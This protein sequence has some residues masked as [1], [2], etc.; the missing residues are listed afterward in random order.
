MSPMPRSDTSEARAQTGNARRPGSTAATTP[1]R[2][3][4][5]RGLG[6]RVLVL[7]LIAAGQE[8]AVRALFPL[9]EVEGFNRV[10]YQLMAGTHPR[11]RATLRRGLVYDQVV[12]ES[13]PDG[14]RETHRLNIYGFRSNDFAIDPPR[15]RGRILVIGDSVAEGQGA[16]ESATI[17]AELSRRTRNE[18]NPPEILNLGVIAANLPRLTLLTRDAVSLLRPTDVIL[19][20]YANDLP[21]PP[22][23]PSLDGPAAPVRRLQVEPWLPRLVVLTGQALADEPIH[24]RWPRRSIRFFPAVPDPANPWT[25]AEKPPPNVQPRLFQEMRAGTL[26]PWLAEQSAALPGMLRHDF[27]TGG[28]PFPYLSRIRAICRQANATL[29]IAYV[30]FCGVVHHH[31]APSLEELGMDP[32]IARALSVDP[33]YHRQ[34]EALRQACAT[35]EVPLAD[36]TADLRL[37][38]EAGER[39]YWEYDTH[40]R[41]SGYATIARRIHQEWRRGRDLREDRSPEPPSSASS[42]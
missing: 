8:A 5:W 42:R 7:T 26:N 23:L 28:S 12:V 35:L 29:T 2:P 20:L 32:E 9:P 27:A 4:R 31:Y 36:A 22:Y 13:R 25:G 34:N 3:R 24:R 14:F 18:P 41:P 16:P 38:E 40:P 30:P 6:F 33:L 15:G 37:A 21:S 11:F 39:Q 1:A 10:R 17:A 19:V